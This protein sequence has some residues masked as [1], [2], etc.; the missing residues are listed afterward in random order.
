[1]ISQRDDRRTV[2]AVTGG[3]EAESLTQGITQIASGNPLGGLLR[4]ISF[5]A[6][7]NARR[8]L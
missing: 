7:K 1:M 8:F 6:F 4:Y 3:R 5:S 2:L